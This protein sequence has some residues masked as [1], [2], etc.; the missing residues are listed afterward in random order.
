MESLFKDIRYGLRMLF[1]NRGFAAVALLTLALGIGGNTAIFSVVN[2]VLLRP[3][4][5]FA[6]ERLVFVYNSIRGLYPKMGL[7]EAEFLRLREQ[8]RS[9]ERVSLYTSATMT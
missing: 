3:L 6:P 7:M 1:K 4:P 8:A 9:L 5:Y 2:T